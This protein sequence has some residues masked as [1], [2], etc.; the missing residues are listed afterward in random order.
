[1][2][3]IA[4]EGRTCTKCGV[5]G[6]RDMFKPSK[7]YASGLASW[8]RK[9]SNRYVKQWQT[10][11]PEKRNLS[12]LKSGLKKRYGISVERY[13]ELYSKQLGKCAICSVA[14]ASQVDVAITLARSEKDKNST[15]HVDH[16]HKTGIVRGLLCSKCNTGIGQLQ[17]SVDIL[18]SA[19]RYIESAQKIKTP[20]ADK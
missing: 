7:A 15:A 20:G 10:E 17:E 16:C 6:G 9:C 18:E 4:S 14:V 2:M 13:L 5:S 1:M 19:I 3:Q 12:E 11:N 8:C